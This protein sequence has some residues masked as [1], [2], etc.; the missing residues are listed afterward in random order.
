[1]RD[2]AKKKKQSTRDE[3]KNKHICGLEIESICKVVG[4]AEARGLA[5]VQAGFGSGVEAQYSPVLTWGQSQL[6]GIAPHT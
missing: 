6:R 2:N 4:G 1:M 5:G 3:L